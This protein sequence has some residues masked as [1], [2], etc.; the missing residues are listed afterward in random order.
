MIIVIRFNLR[1]CCS[2]QYVKAEP[3]RYTP[4]RRLRGEEYMSCSFSISALDGGEW[5][6]SRPG[7]VLPPGKGPPGTHG[8]GGWVGPRANL[9]TEVRGKISSLCRGSKPDRPVRSQTLYCLSYPAALFSMYLY[10][11]GYC[12]NI[13]VMIDSRFSQP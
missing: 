13:I 10:I 6:A 11:I 3:S 9:D 12:D 7:R 4:W 5:S 1:L 8:T 2:I